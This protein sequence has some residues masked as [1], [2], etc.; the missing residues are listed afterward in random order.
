MAFTKYNP[1][2][3]K[4]NVRDETGFV[5]TKNDG[6]SEKVDIIR[7]GNVV[8]QGTPISAN[9]MNK[10][11]NGV[12]DVY[13]YLDFIEQQAQYIITKENVVILA[14]NWVDDTSN[15][16][17]WYNDLSYTEITDESIVDV[18][19]SISDMKKSIYM[20][21]ANDSFDGYVRIY[22]TRDVDDDL[23]CDIKIVTPISKGGN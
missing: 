8:V 7:A 1:T 19:I 22:S 4:D 20:Q 13:D 6:S 12:A 3:W 17:Y 9:T 10:L 14:S 18:N 5:M 21:S 15:S 2:I 16:G 11:E 23:T